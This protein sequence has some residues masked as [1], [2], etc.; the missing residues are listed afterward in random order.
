MLCHK[1]LLTYNL[2]TFAWTW[3][4]AEI[5]AYTDASDNVVDILKAKMKA[6]TPDL[7]KMLQ[8]ASFLGSHFEVVS[9][10]PQCRR[11]ERWVHDKIHEAAVDL[12][13]PSDRADWSRRIGDI[14]VTKLD[15]ETLVSAIFLV[16]KLLNDSSLD[17]NSSSNNNNNNHKYKDSD[18]DV[19][20]RVKWAQ[21]NCQA[22]VEAVKVSAFESAALYA[23]KGIALLPEDC[24]DR[25]YDLSLKLYSVGAK[26]EG[27]I[28]NVPAMERY[29]KVVLEQQDK[30]FED[31]FDVY[32]TLTDGIV[33]ATNVQEASDLLYD[34]LGKFKC[35]FPK[36][37]L[38]VG[39]GVVA[40]VFRIKA[41]MKSRDLSKLSTMQDTTR[42]ELMRFLDKLASCCYILKDC[43]LP[44]VIFRTLNWTLKYGI[45]DQSPSAFATTGMILT[46]LLDDIKGGALYGEH[47]LNLLKD[48]PSRAT[49]SRTMMCV[50]A[51][52]FSWTKPYQSLIKPLLAAYDIGL[53]TGDTESA[54]GSILNY[55]LLQLL[56]GH[57][58]KTLEG[59][60]S[61]YSKQM[62]DL[63]RGPNLKSTKAM[64]QAVL[65]LMGRNNRDG[66]TRFIGDS[67][68]Q[69]DFEQSRSEKFWDAG[70]YFFQGMLFT[71]FGEHAQQADIM[72][73]KGHDYIAK[74]HVAAATVMTD[75]CLKGV[76]CFAMARRTGKKKYA[77]LG[78][79]CRTR[80]KRWL[81]A[82]N[83][84][85]TRYDSLL[86]AEYMAY[87][88]QNF[89]A[90]KHY[91]I[92][93]LLAAR[94]GFQQDA[95]FASERLGDFQTEVMKDV[96]E[97]RY[98]IGEAI[99]YWGG[100]GAMAKVEHL[101]QK[102]FE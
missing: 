63:K 91:E 26:A 1:K 32:H 34:I 19:E 70:V 73:R 27:S 28:G 85:V 22:C 15:D 47:A 43:R 52:I 6:C 76:S 4:N 48:A 44:L 58:L 23:R 92:A 40:N 56:S 68:S 8:I 14:L 42:M 30:P 45:C 21:L 97:G 59:D 5:K 74:I 51:Y 93:L 20:T 7:L 83:P 55:M 2:G 61:L 50:Y 88:G 17:D 12:I 80:I 29:C 35:R 67:M 10:S 90:I 65:N 9:D 54:T 33:N 75:Y 87:K 78:M 72:I 49:V 77:K 99:K 36:T 82:G 69:D 53:Q 39:A 13:P 16:V 96:E 71:Y 41:T 37:T 95:A 102:Y 31:K 84:N 98:R 64:Q 81:D 11:Q 100:W 18:D 94:G 66:P 86:E 101:E 62:K 57:S 60:M 24:W 38:A 89:A 3:N 79:L 25:H 46:G